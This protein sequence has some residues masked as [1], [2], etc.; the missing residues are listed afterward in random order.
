MGES[1]AQIQIELDK[2]LNAIADLTHTDVFRL[3]PEEDPNDPEIYRQAHY[4]GRTFDRQRIQEDT[5]AKMP[6]LELYGDLLRTIWSEAQIALASRGK[7]S[8]EPRSYHRA[9]GPTGFDPK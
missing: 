7:L 1:L 9:L 5:T 3:A 2:I 4:R 6:P 8:Q